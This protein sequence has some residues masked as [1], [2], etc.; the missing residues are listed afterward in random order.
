MHYSNHSQRRLPPHCARRNILNTFSNVCRVEHPQSVNALLGAESLV[1]FKGAGFAF[2]SI[3][4]MSPPSHRP[5]TSAKQ[6]TYSL[7][8]TN[9][10]NMLYLSCRLGHG[11]CPSSRKSCASVAPSLK[12]PQNPQSR[13]D[14]HFIISALA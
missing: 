3:G 12:F 11:P 9:S 10:N 5:S 13:P 14:Y 7:Y 8:L 6:T 4:P 2:A 1:V